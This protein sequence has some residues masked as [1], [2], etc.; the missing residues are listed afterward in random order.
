MLEFHIGLV[1]LDYLTELE[2]YGMD[3]VI[4]TIRKMTYADF[5]SI[6]QCHYWYVN[7]LFDEL[8]ELTFICRSYSEMRDKL[9]AIWERG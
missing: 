4:F 8:E 2:K 6:L 1:K 5:Y 9:L 7:D 3:D